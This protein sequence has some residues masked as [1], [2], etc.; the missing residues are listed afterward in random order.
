MMPPND[1]LVTLNSALR[2]PIYNFEK[3]Y[4]IISEVPGT[5][6]KSNVEF[7]LAPE[8]E[9]ILD[10]RGQKHHYGI[11]SHGF[12]ILD[13]HSSFA[14]WSNKYAIESQ[15]LLEVKQIISNHLD[16]VDEVHIFGWRV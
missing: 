10:L 13:H 1:E 11:D 9:R 2:L 5:Y 7:S 8:P 12:Q 16:E 4:Q 15:Y 6:K 14:D 3:P